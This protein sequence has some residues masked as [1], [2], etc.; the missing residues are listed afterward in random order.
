M[1][2]FLLYLFHIIFSQL[3]RKLFKKIIEYRNIDFESIDFLNKLL[4]NNYELSK[5]ITVEDLICF[6]DLIKYNG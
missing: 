2:S 6:L 5:N 1:V 3:F 4:Q